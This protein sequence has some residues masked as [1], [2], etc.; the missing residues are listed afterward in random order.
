M[1]QERDSKKKNCSRG[2]KQ[3]LL[4][5]LLLG[6]LGGLLRGL[7][8]ITDCNSVAMADELWQVCVQSVVRDKILINKIAL[9]AISNGGL[10]FYAANISF[11]LRHICSRM[12]IFYTALNTAQ[13]FINLG[14]IKQI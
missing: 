3:I 1:G 4:N 5:C 6:A 2:G 9:L 7:Q 13:V 10:I 11:P 12:R 14:L 8:G